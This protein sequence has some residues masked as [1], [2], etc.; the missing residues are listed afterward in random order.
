MMG[1]ALPGLCW[2]GCP[3]SGALPAGSHRPCPAWGCQSSMVPMGRQGW[4]RLQAA[5]C[6][7]TRSYLDPSPEWGSCFCW[8][9][10]ARSY[11]S[12][13]RLQAPSTGLCAQASREQVENETHGLSSG[14]PRAPG[15]GVC[16]AKTLAHGLPARP[17]PTPT[18]GTVC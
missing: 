13:H 8:P 10:T 3:V 12:F 6:P 1:P 7:L 17:V 14:G 9:S 4:W 18:P 11:S 16:E 5:L 15:S 2:C